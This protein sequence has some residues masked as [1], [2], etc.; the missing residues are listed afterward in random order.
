[1]PPQV[2]GGGSQHLQVDN[3]YSNGIQGGIVPVATGMALAEKM[4]RPKE[5]KSIIIVADY[6]ALV[7]VLDKLDKEISNTVLW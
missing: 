6:E 7:P 1:M 4:M 5:R 2:E 3:F